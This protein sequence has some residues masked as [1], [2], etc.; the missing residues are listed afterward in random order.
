MIALW[1]T[2]AIL[3]L[4]FLLTGARLV[5]LPKTTLEKTGAHWVTDVP[6]AA[7]KL[8]GVGQLLGAVGL[9]LPLATGNAPVLVPV[10]AA[11]LLIVMVGATVVHVRRHENP[12]LP[13]ITGA[14]TL[15]S[16]AVAVTFLPAA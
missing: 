1:A 11:C 13:I 15:A 14:V 12:I 4:T 16:F 9:V 7:V 3:A 10:A 5:V 6:T 2:N 8:L